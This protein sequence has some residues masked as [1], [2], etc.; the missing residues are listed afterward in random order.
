M[1]ETFTGP[2]IVCQAP[3]PENGWKI[4]NVSTMAPGPNDLVVEMIAVGICHT[5]VLFGTVKPPHPLANYPGIKGHEGSG[6][7]RAIGS[8]VTVAAVGDPVLL[9]FTWCEDCV[10]CKSGHRSYCDRFPA[11]NFMG[12]ETFT[13]ENGGK[14]AGSFF[15]Q[16]SF[17]KYSVVKSNSV[18]NVKS[19]GLSEEELKLLAPLGCGIQT[20]SGTVVNTAKPGKDDCVAVLGVGGVGLSAIMGAKILGC[21]VILG[22]DIVKSRLELAMELGATHVIDSSDLKGKTLEETVKEICD[23]VGPHGES[24]SLAICCISIKMLTQTVVVDTTGRPELIDAALEFLRPKGQF[25]QVGSTPMEFN[26]SIPCFKF[27][28]SGKTYRGVIEGDSYP[29]EYVPKMIQWYKEGRFPVDKMVKFFKAEEYEKGL[30]EMVSSS[31]SKRYQLLTGIS[32]QERRSSLSCCGS[33][34]S[35]C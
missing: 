25:C 29:P 11:D 20:G 16:S 3:L 1:P 24:S 23:D 9:S 15:G 27:M 8:D 32:I 2:A 13:D 26:L 10:S 28:N 17:A 12:H 21:R 35:H 34:Q 22:V 6:Y 14:I 7:V 30:H 19:L 31:D 4:Q 5:D 18:V 33:A